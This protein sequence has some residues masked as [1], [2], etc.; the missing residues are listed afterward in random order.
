MGKTGGEQRCNLAVDRKGGLEAKLNSTKKID[1]PLESKDKKRRLN[2]PQRNVGDYFSSFIL[3]S[4]FV[5]FIFEG[6]LSTGYIGRPSILYQL[7]AG[8]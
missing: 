4:H 5:R 6:I 3:K 7:F 1:N 8:N 2:K